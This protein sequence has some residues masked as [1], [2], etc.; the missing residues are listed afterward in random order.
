LIDKSQYYRDIRPE[1]GFI[2]RK[3]ALEET[4]SSATLDM[5][6]LFQDRFAYQQVVL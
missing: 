2:D 3:A 1:A 4:N 5:A 6:N